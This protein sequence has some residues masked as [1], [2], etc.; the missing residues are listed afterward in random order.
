MKST[1]RNIIYLFQ[2]GE[3]LEVDVA[4]LVLLHMLQ[5]KA[6][7]CQVTVRQ[8]ILQMSFS[9]HVEYLLITA[10]FR[11]DGL[12][13][14]TPTGRLDIVKNKWNAIKMHLVTVQKEA[15]V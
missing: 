7:L 11:L 12:H 10:F 14:S 2:T 15:V 4:L 9:L 8:Q 1:Q 13:Q 3:K 5:Q 6:I